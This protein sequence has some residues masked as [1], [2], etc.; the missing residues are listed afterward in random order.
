MEPLLD[1]MGYLGV[2][3]TA[4]QLRNRYLRPELGDR[5]RTLREFYSQFIRPGDLVFDIGANRGDRTEVFVQMGARVVAVE[6]QP[7][8]A[9]R[10]RAIFRYSPVN[11]EAVGIGRSPGTLPLH[12]CSSSECSSFSEDFIESQSGGNGSAR[13]DRTEIVPIVTADSL[14]EKYGLPAFVKID[15]EGFEGEVLAGLTRAV[16]SLSFEVRP[17]DAMDDAVTCLEHLSRLSSYEF[18]LSLE[19]SLTFQLPAWGDG[20]RVTSALREVPPSHWRFGDVYARRV[21]ARPN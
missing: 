9:A 21:Q 15:V 17:Q 20:G 16:P 19:E 2:Y 14:I 5:S 18:N 11:V 7:E 6:P 1:I 4:R 12:V 3:R 10:L 8:L 13:W